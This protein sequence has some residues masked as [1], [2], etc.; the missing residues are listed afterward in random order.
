[1][2]PCKKLELL[3]CSCDKYA[4]V[5]P[6]FFAL[7]FKYWNDC[8][9]QINLIANELKYDDPRVTTIKTNSKLD[10]SSAFCEALEKVRAPY[11]LVVME[12]YLL[13][14]NVET[15]RF[16]ELIEH[17]EKHSIDCLHVY[18]EPIFT[19]ANQHAAG[20]KLGDVLPGTPYR[21]NLQAAIWNTAFL[22]QLVKRGENAWEFE[23]FGSRRSNNL[24]GKFS[25]VV[26]KPEDAPFPYY[27]T[28]VVRGKWMPGAVRL[29]KKEGIHIDFSKRKIG[30]VRGMFREWPVLQPVR[31]AFVACKRL[32]GKH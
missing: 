22:K 4:D 32:M 23:V 19:P 13:T 28:G 2:T 14:R 6:V 24:Q 11:A 8:P 26:C 21:V 12:D 15:S 3:V 31:H 5:W 29:C 16:A 20:Y 27:C 30:W 7:F 1:M 10:W 25:T 9:H 17:M 18:P